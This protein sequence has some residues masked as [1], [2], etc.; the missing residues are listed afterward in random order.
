MWVMAR[1]DSFLQDLVAQSP[2]VNFIPVTIR[3]RFD[4]KA[5][6]VLRQVITDHAI[7][8][9]NAQSSKDRYVSVL[10]RWL[11][12]L[13][14]LVF[15]TRRQVSMSI[16]GFFQ[17]LVYVSG[18]DKVIA[19]SQGIQQSLVQKGIP[20]AHIQVIYNG[21]PPS[22][23]QRSLSD[24][25]ALRQAWSIGTEETVVGCI[26]RRK[27]QEDLLLALRH[28]ERPLTVVFSG[29][30]EDSKLA[31]LRQA[32]PAQHRVIYTGYTP[33]EQALSWLTIFQVFV[34]C[35]TSEGLSQS[36]LE[37][38][39]SRVPVVATRAAG[40]IDLIRPGE[41]GLLYAVDDTRELTHGI[42]Q[43]LTDVTL[44]TRLVE[45]AFITATVTF[46]ID[47]TV[48]AYEN[49]FQGMLSSRQNRLHAK[50]SQRPLP[51]ACI[52]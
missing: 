44:R 51:T 15:H 5:I 12:R 22:K 29:I 6:R 4:A 40:N 41:N 21:L 52:D 48:L 11:F 50:D 27:N 45:D 19:V 25:A 39:Y 34:L 1:P 36:L 32:L 14:V 38:M 24:P 43:L 37:A 28:I 2:G 23:F 35:S 33:S 7:Q 3:S 46:S 31:E 20:P 9:V 30:D 8:V 26:S 42:E 49:F 16:G 17:N 47:R 10:T 13:D 18:T